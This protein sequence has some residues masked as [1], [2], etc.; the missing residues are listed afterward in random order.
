M[1]HR[2]P[3]I[4]CLV[5]IACC[6]SCSKDSNSS[7]P[8]PSAALLTAHGWKIKSVLYKLKNDNASTD[9][10]QGLY[11][12][13]ELDDIY[14]FY[15]DSIFERTDSTITCDQNSSLFGPWGV[16]SWVP[17]STFSSIT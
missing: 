12:P 15:A 7:P 8:K 10:T 6:F 3:L 1:L 16:G 9:L 17:D 14:K 5:I 13:C 11:H 4:F 2:L